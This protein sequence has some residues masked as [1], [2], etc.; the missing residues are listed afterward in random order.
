M[1]AWEGLVLEQSRRTV[2]SSFVTKIFWKE[3]GVNRVSAVSGSRVSGDLHI[4]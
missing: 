2:C 1:R 3:M 4:E